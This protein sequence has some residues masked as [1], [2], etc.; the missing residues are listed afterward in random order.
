MP[1]FLLLLVATLLSGQPTVAPTP[2]TTAPARGDRIGPYILSEAFEFGYRFAQIDGNEGKYRSDVNFRNGLRLLSSSLRLHSRDGKARWAD[3]VL[4]HTQGLGNDP[5]QIARVS[6]RHNRLYEYSLV[7]RQNEYFNPALPIAGGRHAMDTVHRLQDHSLTL[8]PRSPV[9]FLVG[10]QR[11]WQGG[12]ALTTLNL[13]GSTGDEFN[14]LAPVNRVQNGY[15]FGMD[16]TLSGWRWSVLRAWDFYRE[17]LPAQAGAQPGENVLDRNAL[18][19]LDRGES[20]RGSSPFWR[21]HFARPEGRRFTANG[22]Y[23]YVAGQRRARLD[24]SLMGT[25]RF[26]AFN[27]QLLVEG[28]GRRPVSAGNLT[29]AWFP[30]PALT[31]THHFG[32]HHTRMEGD[33]R[34][35]ELNNISGQFALANFQF[36]GVQLLSNETQATWRPARWFTAF[37][38]Y[39]TSH[40]RI[41]SIEQQEGDGFQD[42]LE[43]EQRNRQNAGLAGV[44]FRPIKGLLFQGSGEVGRNERP[45]YPVSDR[46]YHGVNGLAQY[47]RGGWRLQAQHRNNYNFNGTGLAAFGARTRHTSAE[48]S[49][50]ALGPVSWEASFAKLNLE[51]L[52]ALSYFANLRRV[53]GDR[54]LYVSNLYTGTAGV[55]VAIRKR[56][57]VYVGYTRVEDAGDGR[58]TADSGAAASVEALR[59]AQVFPVA[60]DSPQ[61]RISVLV[62]NKVRW[63]AGYQYYRYQEEFSALQNYRAHTGFSSLTWSF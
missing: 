17:D 9:R 4:V 2:E 6:A 33:N 12:P 53:T 18:N 60:F 32:Y 22:R 1:L 7:W 63:N 26:G 16:A 29:V 45:F 51:S 42:R 36:L 3:E 43:S 49:S 8:L 25:D 39:L 30:F 48:V 56:A 11:N 59:V 46:D 24:E 31:V 19:R 55:R 13:N 37:G 20:Y 62:R 52:A 35:V 44:Q 61:I 40:R 15:R 10:Y 34:F 5:Y 57:D 58:A 54:S 47:T 41:R 38:G 23:S 50:A 28:F 21:L 27:R 14:L